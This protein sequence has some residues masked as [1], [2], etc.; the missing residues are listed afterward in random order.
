[1]SF[2]FILCLIALLVTPALDVALGFTR[3]K[4]LNFGAKFGYKTSLSLSSADAWAHAQHASGTRYIITGIV[5]SIVT[6]LIMRLVPDTNAMNL[7]IFSVTLFLM[8]SVFEILLISSVES[9]LRAKYG[10]KVSN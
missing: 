3:G 6:V 9:E 10:K 4:G 1:M 5:M 7:Y 2:H 8:Q